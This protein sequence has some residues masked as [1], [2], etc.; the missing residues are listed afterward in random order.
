M[1]VNPQTVNGQQTFCRECWQCRKEKLHD[2]I[3][4]CIAEQEISDVTLA[5]TLTYADPIQRFKMD[6]HFDEKSWE[7]EYPPEELLHAMYPEAGANTAVLVYKDFQLFLKRLRAYDRRIER[8]RYIVAGEYGSKKGRAHWHTILFIKGKHAEQCLKEMGMEINRKSRFKPWRNGHTFFQRPDVDGFR[9]VLKYIIKDKEQPDKRTHVSM[10]KGLYRDGEVIE[11]PL[12]YDYFMQRAEDMVAKGVH[13]NN[14]I[15][16]FSHVRNYKGKLLKFRMTGRTREM[17]EERYTKLWQEKYGKDPIT[18]LGVKYLDKT[19][20]EMWDLQKNIKGSEHDWPHIGHA[21][22]KTFIHANA[23]WWP[24]L[25][26]PW[27][28]NTTEKEKENMAKMVSGWKP[29]Y[30]TPW[31]DTGEGMFDKCNITV[32][33]YQGIQTRLYKDAQQRCYLQVEEEPWQEINQAVE[34]EIRKRGK[35][36][37]NATHGQIVREVLDEMPQGQAQRHLLPPVD[38]EQLLEELRQIQAQL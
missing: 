19:T 3:G 38:N 14:R 12:G 22:N 30:Y 18:E 13:Y 17:F 7:G 33:N 1:C 36:L 25:G 11:G 24:H 23:P 9:Y 21:W 20:N 32:V 34:S 31:Q 5:L 35:E 10:T 27:R 4:R 37:Y 2:Y 15:Y 16:K 26:K 6:Y 8:V 28:R 29:Q